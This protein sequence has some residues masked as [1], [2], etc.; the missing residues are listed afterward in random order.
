MSFA[1]SPRSCARFE[2]ACIVIL[3]FIGWLAP[4]C[5]ADSA[6]RTLVAPP[7][8]VRINMYRAME[9]LPPLSNDPKMSEGNQ[10]HARYLATNFGDRVRGGTA[11]PADMHTEAPERSGFTKIGRSA[12][13]H[14]EV[15]FEIGGD[16]S[17]AAGDPQLGRRPVASDAFAQS[18]ARADRL[19]LLLRQV[20]LRTD[21]E[22]WTS[23]K[24]SLDADAQVAIEFPPANSTVSLYD[25]PHRRPIR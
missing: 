23:R 9:G 11:T 22:R 2:I 8:L 10:N 12:A 19:R 7:W 1:E 6:G 15:D 18:G 4:P 5:A 14:C 16:Q 3:S 20:G 17:Q 21:H 13:P 25:L 24:K